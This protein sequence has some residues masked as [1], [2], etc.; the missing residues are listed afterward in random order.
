VLA[1]SA[2]EVTEPAL[3]AALV[4]NFAKFAEW[5]VESLPP[6]ADLI[7]CVVGDETLAAALAR[8]AQ[9][10]QLAGHR[11]AITPLAPEA[12]LRSCHLLY[13]AGVTPAQTTRILAS[14]ADMPMLTISDMEHFAEAGGIVQLFVDEGRMRFG[15]NLESAKHARLQL[16]SRLMALATRL[17]NEPKG[18]R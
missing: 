17:W 18:G 16:S 7:A 1:A 8:T 9:G 13:L 14:V 10:R 5:P 6:N 4:F 3:K 15:L 11:P 12:S 2:Q